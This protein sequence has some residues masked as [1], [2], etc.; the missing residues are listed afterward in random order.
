[1]KQYIDNIKN[2]NLFSALEYNEIAEIS[3]ITTIKHYPKGYMV[4]Q[5]GDEGDTLYII[6]NG[7]IKVSLYDDEGREYILDI[8]GKDGFFGELS[9]ID[10]LPRSAN[11]ITIED[12]E[13]LVIKKID[14]LKL[15]MENPAIAISVLKTLSKRLRAA[16]ERI[17]GFAFLSVEGR[18]LRYLTEIGEKTGI[19]IKNYL[20]IENGP[21]Q[22]EIANSC[23]CSRETVSRM[24]KSL[25]QKGIISARKRRYT[26]NLPRTS[27]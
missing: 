18:I 21:T 26:I 5:E 15:F 8:I 23:G 6:I 10:D 14:L 3:R 17:R 19:K 12:S 13:F 16:D 1:M 11:I 7:R 4:F 20:I 25:T 2:V 22:I 27:L 24:L 9:I